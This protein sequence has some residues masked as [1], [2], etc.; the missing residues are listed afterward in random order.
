[1]KGKKFFTMGLVLVMLLAATGYALADTTDT[2]GATATITA[3]SLGTTAHT[4]VSIAATLAGSDQTVY[5]SDT[6]AWTGEDWTGSGAGWHVNISAT[7][8]CDTG[9]DAG[10]TAPA[11]VIPLANFK[12]KLD[13]GNIAQTAGST[14]LPTTQIS[15]YTALGSAQ[16]ILSAAATGE[17]GMG[18]YEYTPD[19]SLF[20]AA[21]EYA[22]TYTST[23]SVEIL[24]TP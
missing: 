7:A 9:R 23:V 6:T 21:E 16:S 14:T 20:V 17:A 18:A 4:V 11:A 3:G 19:F 12:V 10:C 13:S 24:T 15:S 8:L 5:D 1:M 22:G 2:S